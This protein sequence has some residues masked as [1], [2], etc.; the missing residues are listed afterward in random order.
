MLYDKCLSLPTRLTFLTLL[1]LIAIMLGRLEMDV[2]ECIAAYSGLAEA[3][4]SQKKSRFPFSLRGRTTARFNSLR[5][6]DAIGKTIRDAKC[7]EADLFN[8]GK[9]RGCRT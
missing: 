4:F 7:S 2:D 1:S 9:E 3:V 8:D 6:E 5:L